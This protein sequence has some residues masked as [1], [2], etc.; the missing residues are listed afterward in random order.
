M[1]FCLVGVSGVAVD[2]MVLHL[3]ASPAHYGWN[4]SFSKL[5]SAEA[6]LLN[7]FFWNEVWTFR[8]AARGQRTAAAVARRLWRFHAICGIGIGLAVG[9][10]HVFYG[11]IGINLYVANLLAIVLLTLWN[12]SMNA[13]FNWRV[14]AQGNVLRAPRA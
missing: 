10:L 4:V 9:L 13:V 12:F 1:K 11:L 6:A 14:R 3:L 2:M 5:C 7:N 8:A